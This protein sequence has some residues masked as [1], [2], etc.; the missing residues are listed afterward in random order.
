MYYQE[1]GVQLLCKLIVPF[2]LFNFENY[3]YNL[4][5]HSIK[6]FNIPMISIVRSIGITI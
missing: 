4:I 2:H 5:N 1:K 6:E 3:I